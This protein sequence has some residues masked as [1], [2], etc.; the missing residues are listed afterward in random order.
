L[1]MIF[2][3]G[4]SGLITGKTGST[5]TTAYYLPEWPP[6]LWISLIFLSY[7]LL[8]FTGIRP[9]LTELKAMRRER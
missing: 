4:L 7:V 9:Y 2:C 8:F 5:W 3:I 1:S 6:L